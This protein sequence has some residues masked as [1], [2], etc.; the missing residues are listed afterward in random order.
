MGYTSIRA[1]FDQVGL[2]RLEPEGEVSEG[3]QTLA[4]ADGAG[5]R[6][7]NNLAEGCPVHPGSF[8]INVSYLGQR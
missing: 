6:K 5:H 8:L 4:S 1:Y 2:L 7:R 3:I